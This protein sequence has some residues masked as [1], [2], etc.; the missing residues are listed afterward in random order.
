[1]VAVAVVVL[2]A[3]VAVVVEV[4]VH[5]LIAVPHVAASVPPHLWQRSS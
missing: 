3:L 1:M 2:V 4:H 5:W